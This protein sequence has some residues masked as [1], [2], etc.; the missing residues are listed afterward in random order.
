MTFA[1]FSKL[2]AG[3]ARRF[4]I[5]RTPQACLTFRSKIQNPRS[6]IP[7]PIPL[8]T[9]YNP[10]MP[11]FLADRPLL[12][13][14]LLAL[15]LGAVA[16]GI[17]LPD[18]FEDP[19][20]KILGDWQEGKRSFYVSVDEQYI[21]WSRGTKSSNIPYKW[22]QT[23]KEPYT[24]QLEYNHE[25]IA[26]DLTF[27]GDDTAV[28]EPRIWEKLPDYAQEWIRTRNRAAGRPEKEFAI[29]FRREQPKKRR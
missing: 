9:R 28:A 17:L 22:L 20:K 3:A 11:S 10:L 15:L 6:K 1:E 5:P 26:V 23:D 19:R 12:R 18:W 21:R 8:P 27:D 4:E 29:L 2:G 24:L 25:Q 14:G 7:L 13:V 16:C